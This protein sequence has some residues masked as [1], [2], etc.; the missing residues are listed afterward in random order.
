[1]RECGLMDEQTEEETGPF[2]AGLHSSS[3]SIILNSSMQNASM[4]GRA[5]IPNQGPHSFVVYQS[6]PNSNVQNP[7]SSISRQVPVQGGVTKNMQAENAPSGNVLLGLNNVNQPGGRQTRIVSV[8]RLPS[9][10]NAPGVKR[11]VP[12]TIASPGTIPTTFGKAVTLVSGIGT[13]I[14]A[15]PRAASTGVTATTGV[16]PPIQSPL[17][18]FQQ[19]QSN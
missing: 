7:N 17:Q 19:F 2:S 4:H 12:L 6:H 16:K 14:V 10:A 15:L 1:M 5:V 9:V 3:P 18:T 13:Q 8:A 11:M